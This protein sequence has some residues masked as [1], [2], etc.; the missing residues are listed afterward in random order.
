MR[1]R[2]DSQADRIEN[3]RKCGGQQEWAI[4]SVPCPGVKLAVHFLNW[5]PDP[6]RRPASHYP[7]WEDPITWQ[8]LCV[9]D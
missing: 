9:S 4:S 3:E 2:R 1:N 7:D 6:S 8:D 5:L